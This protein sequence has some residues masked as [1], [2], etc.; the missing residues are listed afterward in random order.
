MSITNYD[1]ITIEG[2]R[3][4]FT[5]VV[6]KRLSEGWKLHGHTNI[7]AKP[8]LTNLDTTLRSPML[9]VYSQAIIKTDT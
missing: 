6:N 9:Y 5:T 8:R 7:M 1:L 4:A 3:Q 2:T